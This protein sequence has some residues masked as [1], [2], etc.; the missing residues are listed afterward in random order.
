MKTRLPR[1][2]FY[3]L[4][5]THYKKGSYVAAPCIKQKVFLYLCTIASE[6]LNSNLKMHVLKLRNLNSLRLNRKQ[7][8]VLLLMKK[9][10]WITFFSYDSFFL[11]T[12][13][14]TCNYELNG[15]ARRHSISSKTFKSIYDSFKT[16]SLSAT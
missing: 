1:Y 9:E 12:H 2:Y 16:M 6:L 8:D 13:S 11:N 14:L 3:R 4:I 15:S 10:D 5:A 7:I